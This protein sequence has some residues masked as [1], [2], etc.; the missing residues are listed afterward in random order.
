MRI[1]IYHDSG[2]I[3]LKAEY[4]IEYMTM[5]TY[6]KWAKLLAKHG[7][8]EQH[9]EFL[10]FLI[11]YITGWE[12]KRAELA[13]ELMERQMKADGRLPTQMTSSYWQK[14]VKLYQSKLNGADSKLKRYK[15]MY[16]VLEG[17]VS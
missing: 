12:D 9:K 4:V 10:Q 5:T 17:L 8:T 14:Q 6:R 13:N 16:Q 11:P 3:E 15:T 1:K 7:T 2:W